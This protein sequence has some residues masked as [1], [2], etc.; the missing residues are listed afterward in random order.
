MNCARCGR[1]LTPTWC[2]CL[3]LAEVASGLEAVYELIR[4]VEHGAA[5]H[6]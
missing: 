3:P 1:P 2:V 5:P 4:E 6:G